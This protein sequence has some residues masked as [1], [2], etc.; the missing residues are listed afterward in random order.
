LS[1]VLL[2]IPAITV[3]ANTLIFGLLAVVSLVIFFNLGKF[4]A[5]KSQTEREDR[6]DWSVR[7]YSFSTYFRGCLISGLGIFLIFSLLG[8]LGF[9]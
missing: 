8:Y 4:K 9:N 7:K 3:D 2:T 5:S 1:A 6:I